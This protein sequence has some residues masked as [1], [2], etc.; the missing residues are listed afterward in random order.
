MFSIDGPFL[1]SFNDDQH[2]LDV[3]DKTHK[4]T[5]TDEPQDAAV[6][7]IVPTKRQGEFLIT[8][9]G[10]SHLEKHG[11][12][13]GPVPRHL[14][15][16]LN[17]LGRHSGP[18][19]LT[20]N[21]KEHHSRLTL[22]NRAVRRFRVNPASWTRGDDIFYIKCARRWW[23][24]NGYICVKRNAAPNLSPYTTKCVTSIRSHD[25]EN[26]MLFR[27]IPEEKYKDMKPVLQDDASN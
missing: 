20:F 19:P 17:W 5:V 7:K 13:L 12:E 18:L 8:H 26:F 10:K 27:L 1:I 25:A 14:D 9:T 11:I 6:F 21:A 22:R 2:F 24:I 4:L 16:K 3:D 23:K 15:T